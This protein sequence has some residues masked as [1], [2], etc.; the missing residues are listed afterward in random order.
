MADILVPHTYFYRTLDWL[1]F[2]YLGFSEGTPW[3]LVHL[4]ELWPTLDLAPGLWSTF[5]NFGLLYTRPLNFGP[6]CPPRILTVYNSRGSRPMQFQWVTIPWCR[7][8][9]GG[10][11]HFATGGPR[12]PPPPGATIRSPG[13]SGMDYRDSAEL[14]LYLYRIFI[15]ALNV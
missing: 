2:S 5:L 4:T 6:L 14:F 1:L 12:G 7:E 9:F 3:T 13:H 10:I 15:C 8:R 11:G